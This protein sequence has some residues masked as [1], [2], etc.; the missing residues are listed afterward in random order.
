MKSNQRGFTLVELL[1]AITL[2]SLVIILLGSV[3]LFAQKQYNT[4][5][6]SVNHQKEVRLAMTSITQ[7]LRTV[8]FS[9]DGENLENQEDNPVEFNDNTL[10]IDGDK[11]YHWDEQS[12]T[13][14]LDGA[15]L[16]KGIATF[17]VD[18]CTDKT[19]CTERYIILTIE[20]EQNK[21]GKIAE[22]TSTIYFRE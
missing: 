8:T 21:Q 18:L 9:N 5:T 2:A 11:T 6:E 17:D 22:L 7:Q 1:A 20:S 3:H 19:V 4:Q 10:T 13:I 12:R 14:T 16:T 15:V